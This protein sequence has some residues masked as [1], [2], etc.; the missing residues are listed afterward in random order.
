MLAHCAYDGDKQA[1]SPGRVRRNPL[2]PLRGESRLIPSEPVVTTLVCFFIL[3][4]RLRVRAAHPAF[5]AP[6]F[7]RGA[8][9]RARLGH[10]SAARRRRC[11]QLSSPGLTGRPSIPEALVIEPR[12]RGVLDTRF[13]GYDSG[14]LNPP[15]HCEERERRSNPFF[16]CAA[17][18]IASLALA[19]TVGASV[20]RMEPLAR[21]EGQTRPNRVGRA[22]RNWLVISRRF[23][24]A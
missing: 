22:F 10:E 6:S 3:H 23:D 20:A 17:R 13:R 5:P 16:L 11:I 12:S 2:K 1:R 7:F 4:A 24:E 8:K 18:W 14:R 21:N 15:R 19:M 9:I